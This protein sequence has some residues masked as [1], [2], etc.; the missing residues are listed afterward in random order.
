MKCIY[1]GKEYDLE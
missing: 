1:G